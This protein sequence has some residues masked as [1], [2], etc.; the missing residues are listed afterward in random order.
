MSLYQRDGVDELLSVL[1]D[2]KRRAVLSVLHKRRNAMAVEDLAAAL[3]AERPDRVRTELRHTHLPKLASV[4]LVLYDAQAGSVA[5]TERVR[6]VQPLLDAIREVE[7]DRSPWLF[8]MP[9]E[10]AIRSQQAMAAYWMESWGRQ[11]ESLE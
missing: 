9:F 1:A 2:A 5:A 7:R 3:A 11:F 10:P 6:R 4:D 8:G